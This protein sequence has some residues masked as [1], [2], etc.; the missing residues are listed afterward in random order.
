[1]TEV[2]VVCVHHGPIVAEGSPYWQRTDEDRTRCA[3]ENWKT[4]CFKGQRF[5]K[6]CK[7]RAIKATTF[8]QSRETLQIQMSTTHV[9]KT[10]IDRPR[11]HCWILEWLQ[12]CSCINYIKVEARRFRWDTYTP[13]KHLL[14]DIICL[15]FTQH[16]RVALHPTLVFA[17][18][19]SSA[20]IREEDKSTF[21]GCDSARGKLNIKRLS[22]ILI[23]MDHSDI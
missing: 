20:I 18:F 21:S 6:P 14:S 1:M 2:F 3:T 17:F 13:P 7:K 15:H 10:Q 8:S 9:R 4:L 19:F 5:K 16:I 23:N 11:C 22:G 12:E